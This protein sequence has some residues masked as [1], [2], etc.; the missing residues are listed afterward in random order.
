M[1][2]YEPAPTCSGANQNGCTQCDDIFLQEAISTI[3]EH[4]TSKPLFVTFSPH[5]LHTPLQ[6]S[7]A[8]SEEFAFITEVDNNQATFA[9]RQYHA[10]LSHLDT[11]IGTLVDELKG[12]GLWDNTLFAMFSDNGGPIYLDVFRAGMKPYDGGAN[13]YPLRGGKL[14]DAEGGVRVNSFVAG[15]YVP[16]GQRGKTLEGYMATEDWYATFCDVAG[17]SSFDQRANETGQTP[18]DSINLWPYI[19]G[20]TTES[21]REEVY[22]NSATP[23]AG[24]TAG[25]PFVQYLTD[26]DGYKLIIGSMIDTVRTGPVY[27]NATS[28]WTE[29]EK[30]NKR[31]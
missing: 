21:P 19:S 7:D 11:Q 24:I 6:P 5:S 13:N 3:R 16:E 26:K 2:K 9:R 18:I 4:D 15:G 17:V 23:F 28:N 20:E 22:G 8:D 27:P 25:E 10:M 29:S 12:K 31:N 1:S 14:G 30:N